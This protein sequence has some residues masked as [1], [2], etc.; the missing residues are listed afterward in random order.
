M[1]TAPGP[2]TAPILATEDSS[3][4]CLMENVGRESILIPEPARSTLKLAPRTTTLVSDVSYIDD[5]LPTSFIHSFHDNIYALLQLTVC[6]C[7]GKTYANKCE[8]LANGVSVS[9]NGECG[10]NNRNPDRPSSGDACQVGS[11]SRMPCTDS[12]EYCQLEEGG[13]IYNTKNAEGVC[14]VKPSA[15]TANI[16]PG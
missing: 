12:K 16:D 8:A 5:I 14:T 13:C 4:S 7:D 2:L 3:A 6:G 9:S 15:C 11:K 1:T 10:D